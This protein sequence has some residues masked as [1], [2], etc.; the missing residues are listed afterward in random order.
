MA[1][2]KGEKIEREGLKVY[3]RKRTLLRTKKGEKRELLLK[4]WLQVVIKIVA[5]V[6]AHHTLQLSI[7]P[8]LSVLKEATSA[9]SNLFAQ[10]L[11]SNVAR[12][13]SEWVGQKR[14]RR[15]GLRQCVIEIISYVSNHLACLSYSMY[16]LVQSG[17]KSCIDLEVVTCIFGL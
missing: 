6:L 8:P 15:S 2:D 13:A 1:D 3:W 5:L 4:S 12:T 11:T 10:V 17:V 9:S 16:C 14:L 7:W